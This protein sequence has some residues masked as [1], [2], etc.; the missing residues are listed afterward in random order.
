MIGADENVTAPVLVAPSPLY[1]V[2]SGVNAQ[3][4]G[5]VFVWAAE[6]SEIE[7][8]SVDVGNLPLEWSSADVP[9]KKVITFVGDE[10]KLSKNGSVRVVLR[11]K[12]PCVQAIPLELRW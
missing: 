11:I 5:Q 1:L 4:T 8:D 6:M 9:G 3:L 12:R 2:R 7:I 10:A